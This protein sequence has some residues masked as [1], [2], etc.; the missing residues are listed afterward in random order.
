MNRFR[1]DLLLL[2]TAFIWGTTFVAQKEA[3]SHMGPLMFVGVRFTFA[4]VLLA[5]LAWF[6]SRNR[7]PAP[8]GRDLGGA[9][10]IGLCLCAG[11]W[12]QQV[13]L[14]STT[15]GNAGFLTAVYIVVVPLVAW[16]FTGHRPRPIVLLATFVGLAG[17]W[18]LA[19]G[20]APSGW[21]RGDLIILAS[22]LVWALHI[23]LVSRYSRSGARPLFLAAVQSALTGL[24]TLPAAC[25]LEPVGL[26][27][28]LDALP[29]ILYAGVV[30]S[31]IA[32]TLQVIAQRHTPAAEAALI[33]SLECVFAA[34]AGAILL[35]EAFGPAE[36]AGAALILAS[37][38]LV[39]AGP[40]FKIRGAGFARVTHDISPL[41]QGGRGGRGEGAKEEID[42]TPLLG[43]PAGPAVAG[44]TSLTED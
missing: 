26:P 20:G 23:N 30:S 32:F 24:I 31:G 29:S 13:A 6:E 35:G 12:M 10:L 4:V 5:P 19:G 3:V 36:R 11:C 39:E 21:G 7:A 22:D 27:A 38:V 15:A 40:I 17:A 1:A 16:L 37:V 28:I 43:P 41:P 42:P 2:V 8:S 33:M 44:S 34:A 25:V 18:L 14:E 9:L